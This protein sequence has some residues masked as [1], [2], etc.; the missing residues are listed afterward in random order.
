MDLPAAAYSVVRGQQDRKR[1]PRGPPSRAGQAIKMGL[2]TF[3]TEIKSNITV[4]QYDVLIGNGV[5]TRGLIRNVWESKAVK[6]SLGSGFIFDGNKLAWSGKSLD[7]EI[8]LVVDLDQ[9]SFLVYN[10]SEA[11]ANYSQ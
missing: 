1:A 9:A 8:R 2:N 11:F 5:E 7:R 10:T 6:K 3:D 4:Y